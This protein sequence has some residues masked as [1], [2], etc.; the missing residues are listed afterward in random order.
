MLELLKNNRMFRRLMGYRIFSGLGGGIFS[1][2]IML[3]V[4]LMYGNPIFTGITGVLIAGPQ[5]FAFTVGP[6]VDRRRKVTIMRVTTLLEFAVIAVLAFT[7][8]IEEVGVIVMFVAVFLFSWAALF[9]LPASTALLPQ[10]VPENKI[11]EANS[12]IQIAAM[13]GGI[14]VAG[15]LFVLLGDTEANLTVIYAFSAIFLA[16]AFLFSVFIKDPNAPDKTKQKSNYI[17]DLK[18][19]GRFI[20]KNVLLFITI[21]LVA[22][23]FFMEIA[24]VNRPAFLETHVGARGY[25]VFTM[26]ALVGG[27]LA[28]SLMGFLGKNFKTGWMISVLF[29]IAGVARILFAFVLPH[30]YAGG[31][32]TMVVYATLGSALGIIMMSLRQRI[33]QKDMVGRVDTITTT[34]SS[35]AITVGALVGGFLGSAVADVANVFMYQGIALVTISLFTILVPS[36]RK[37]PKINDISNEEETEG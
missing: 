37:L 8:I 25:V 31:L 4:H 3:S 6:I 24:G 14:L 1:F 28:S 34:F 33:P 17:Q 32:A 16:I 21:A 19:G 22:E 20:R 5:I 7:P 23:M 27:I 2:F 26:T 18:E 12:L 15:G 9:E 35:I 11:M 36:I 10:I 29:A 13:S 30:S